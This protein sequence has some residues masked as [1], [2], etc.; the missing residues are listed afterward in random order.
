MNIN[1][2]LTSNSI[3][4]NAVI[5]HIRRSLPE[6]H[7]TAEQRCVIRLISKLIMPTDDVNRVWWIV[8]WSVCDH[9]RIVELMNEPSQ[10]WTTRVIGQNHIE[11]KIVWIIEQSLEPVATTDA[12]ANTDGVGSDILQR[13]PHRKQTA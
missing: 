9:W 5:E 3:I 2:D 8:E 1:I 7:T 4:F 13:R 12:L 10:T 11:L 6:R